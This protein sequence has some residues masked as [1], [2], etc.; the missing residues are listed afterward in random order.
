MA[1]IQN[2]KY[3]NDYVT[4]G[5]LKSSMESNNTETD[6]KINEIPKNYNSP[7]VPPYY[8]NSLLLLNGQIYKCIKSRL[9]GSFNISDWKIVVETKDLDEALKTIYD[10]NKLEYV[11][12]EDGLI[13][14]FYQESDPSLN[15]ET[16]LAKN[17]HTSDL[18]TVDGDEIYQYTKK[19][20]NPV[21]YGWVKRRVP[22]SLFDIVDGHKT[23]FLNTP[24]NYFKGDLWIG[25]VTKIAIK[26]STIFDELDWEDRDEYVEAIETEQQE[27]H[28]IYIIPSITEINRQS[29]SEIKKAIDEITLT[30]SQ[31]YTTKTEMM[32]YVD[33]VKTD[34]AEEYTTKKEFNAQLSI[35]SNQFNVGLSVLTETIDTK[36]EATN[37]R[38]NEI[39]NYIRYALENNVGVVTIG[40]SG[41]PIKLKVKNDRISFEQN[42]REVAYISNN[43]LYITDATFLNSMRIGNFAFIPRTNESLGFK[44]V[45]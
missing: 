41:S 16:D 43:T 11:D 17:L 4:L 36:D 40:T 20:T 10:V 33:D 27:Y 18:W 22:I 42:N 21:T 9:V 31:S 35:A 39:N 2:P 24:T 23:I 19:A 7:P 3:D 37:N 45:I 26:N 44:K 29:N 25:K 28:K 12:Q 38:I 5:Y 15:W 6:K 14:T 1:V 30:V 8:Q 34:V 13:E 32:K